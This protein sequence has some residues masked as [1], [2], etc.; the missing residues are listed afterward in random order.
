MRSLIATR[1]SGYPPRVNL[2]FARLLLR[3]HRAARADD[4]PSLDSTDSLPGLTTQFLPASENHCTAGR[5]RRVDAVVCEW[6]RHFDPLAASCDHDSIFA[7]AYLRITEQYRRTI[8]DPTFFEDT[9]LVNHEDAIFAAYYF[10][11]FDAWCA[12]ST[13]GRPACLAAAFQARRPLHA[14][15][16]HLSRAHQRPRR[17]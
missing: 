15:E 12:G 2:L 5:T 6:R 7:L 1:H 3:A 10:K 14:G 13:R 9:A 4:L 11:A 8:E 17:A 16:R